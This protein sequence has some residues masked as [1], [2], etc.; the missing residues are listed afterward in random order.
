MAVLMLLAFYIYR[1]YTGVLFYILERLGRGGGP[2]HFEAPYL[3]WNTMGREAVAKYM[4]RK[5]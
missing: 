2:L 5:K 3:E 4:Y 1:F